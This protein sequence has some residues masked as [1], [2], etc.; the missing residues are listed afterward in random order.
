LSSNKRLRGCH[1]GP[2]LP[3]NT[4]RLLHIFFQ[5]LWFSQITR[6]CILGKR[7]IVRMTYKTSHSL[8]SEHFLN[9]TFSQAS[10]SICQLPFPFPLSLSLLSLSCSLSHSCSLQFNHPGSVFPLCAMH[11]RAS[12]PFLFLEGS[13]PVPI[14]TLTS[15]LSSS[16]LVVWLITF[17]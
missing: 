3:F 15:S 16:L 1:G 12:G 11:F 14:Y 2:F 4:M 9:S 17:P 8:A 13:I 5:L 7:P 6:W 10:L